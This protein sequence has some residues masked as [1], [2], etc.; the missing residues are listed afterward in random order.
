[1]PLEAKGLDLL[2]RDL[3]HTH[4]HY[5]HIAA[6]VF[7]SNQNKTDPMRCRAGS[8]GLTPLSPP[9]VGRYPEQGPWAGEM[10]AETLEDHEES[11][12]PLAEERSRAF[13]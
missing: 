6:L 10:G 2:V 9:H 7:P 11:A 13:S 1:M 12:H 5:F 8:F 3:Q 4:F